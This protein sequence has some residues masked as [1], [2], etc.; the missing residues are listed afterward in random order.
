MYCR[1]CGKELPDDSCFCTYCG[2]RLIVTSS[3]NVKDNDEGGDV[4]QAK[5]DTEQMDKVQIEAPNDQQIDDT[6]VTN[7]LCT[8]D[9]IQETSTNNISA[10]S[11]DI[12]EEQSTTM[13]EVTKLSFLRRLFGSIIDKFIVFILFF[14]IP[15]AI[16]YYGAP[17]RLGIYVGLFNASPRNY[18]YIDKSAMNSYGTYKEG[19]SHYYQEQERLAN[20]PPHIGSTMELDKSMTFYLILLN[21]L[22][23]MLFESLLSASLGK[24][25]TGGVILDRAEDKIVFGN[26]LQRALCRGILMFSLVY[27]LHFGMMLSYHAVLITFFL[28]MDLPVFFTRR[29]LLDIITGTTYAKR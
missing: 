29:S 4:V 7:E 20:D 15:I 19:I 16:D 10:N 2:E 25:I 13:S 23:F 24:R 26:V 22:Y 18:E 27:L 11:T 12:T 14:S 21:V 5:N 28:L 8:N 9:T 17:S 6:S 3:A 1:F